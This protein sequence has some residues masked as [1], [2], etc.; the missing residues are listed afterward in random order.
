MIQEE[1]STWS[2][3]RVTLLEARALHGAAAS[4]AASAAAAE[5]GQLS[6]SR[7]LG[8]QPAHRQL[9]VITS[10]TRTYLHDE[11]NS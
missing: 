5:S 8:W 2:Q 6:V 1:R 7:G 4:A 9:C 10:N 3:R 11:L